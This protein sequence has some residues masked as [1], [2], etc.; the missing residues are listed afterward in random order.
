MG[1]VWGL[2]KWGQVQPHPGIFR[3]SL[4]IAHTS[5]N[6]ENWIFFPPTLYLHI[7]FGPLLG[8][9]GQTVVQD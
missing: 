9:V 2:K 5:F 7:S 1:R 6:D 8:L 3:G 4:P